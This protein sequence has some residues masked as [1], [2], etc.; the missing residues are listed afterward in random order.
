MDPS[1]HCLTLYTSGLTWL[2][3]HS[4]HNELTEIPG[5][6]SK[7]VWLQQIPEGC[8]LFSKVT[9]LSGRW[10]MEGK[11]EIQLFTAHS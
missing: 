1:M 5:Y 2:T 8:Q 11:L 10:V 7:W 3:L 4:K 6:L 9:Y